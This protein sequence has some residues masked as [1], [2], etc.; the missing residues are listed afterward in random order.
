MNRTSN[1]MVNE[2]G[3]NGSLEGMYDDLQVDANRL[4][5]PDTNPAD[6]N[7]I[8]L[9]GFGFKTIAYDEGESMF[10]MLQTTHGTQL[11][12]Q[13]ELH[14]HWT[15][16]SDDV[17]NTFQFQ[18]TGVAASIGTPFTNIGTLKSEV[19]TLQSGDAGNH[20]YLKLADLPAINDEV[21]SVYLLKVTRI[22]PDSGTG[23]NEK[24]YTMFLDAHVFLDTL[25]SVTLT[26]KM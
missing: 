25:G 22:T 9:D 24:I 7:N 17:G 18:V 10:M 1:P 4:Q 23:T 5:A 6:W 21:S 13:P 2:V 8:T 12:T 15:I 19:V 3:S 14:I 16:D 26:S 20:N 11:N